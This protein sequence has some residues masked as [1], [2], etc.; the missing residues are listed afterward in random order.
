MF[1]NPDLDRL[2]AGPQ[3]FELTNEGL[4]REDESFLAWIRRRELQR[5]DLVHLFHE[6]GRRVRS[7]LRSGSLNKGLEGGKLGVSAHFLKTHGW[8]Q[9]QPNL[10]L[11]AESNQ[12]WR[13]S[14]LKPATCKPPRWGQ[15]QRSRSGRWRLGKP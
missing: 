13:N 10:K 1:C 8:K 4:L 14:T 3:T 6:L 7:C 15:Q 9:R 11:H 12:T 5:R 2:R